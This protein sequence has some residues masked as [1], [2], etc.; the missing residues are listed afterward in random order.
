MNFYFIFLK[1]ISIQTNFMHPFQKQ[2]Q[3]A[4]N[5][6]SANVNYPRDSFVPAERSQYD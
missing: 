6:G 3:M 1:E 5:Y 2:V 4:S